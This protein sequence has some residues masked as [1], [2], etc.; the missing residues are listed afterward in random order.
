[1]NQRQASRNYY[2]ALQMQNPDY[3]LEQTSSGNRWKDALGG[4][5]KR[6]SVRPEVA[7]MQKRDYAEKQE[8]RMLEGMALLMKWKEENPG[9]PVPK[10]LQK[11]EF[12]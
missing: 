7:A 11:Y 8:A 6:W 2:D 12:V 9:K 4:A 1:M 3:I 10:D 5:N